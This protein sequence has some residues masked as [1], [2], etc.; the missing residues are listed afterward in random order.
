MDVIFVTFNKNRCRLM[1]STKMYDQFNDFFFDII[2]I[3]DKWSWSIYFEFTLASF[4]IP[5]NELSACNECDSHKLTMWCL[6]AF[7]YFDQKVWLI[8]RSKVVKTFP[9]FAK[10]LNGMKIQGQYTIGCTKIMYYL[11]HKFL[12]REETSMLKSRSLS[13][14]MGK[15]EKNRGSR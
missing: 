5:K 7:V 6:S 9:F 14:L 1:S 4:L 15:K 13:Y 10:M 12:E 2:V 11:W 8:W 3:N